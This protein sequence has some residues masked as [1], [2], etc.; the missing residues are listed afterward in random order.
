MATKVHLIYGSS[1]VARLALLERKNKTALL[2]SS[3]LQKFYLAIWL[4]FGS[5]ATFSFDKFFLEKSKEW[6]V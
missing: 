3:W 1:R 4:L 5:F 6:C 2:R